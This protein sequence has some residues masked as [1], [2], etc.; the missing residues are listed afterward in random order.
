MK[1]VCAN[2]NNLKKGEKSLLSHQRVGWVG[3][4]GPGLSPDDT[5]RFVFHK[6]KG[7]CHLFSSY[8]LPSCK[9][10]FRAVFTESYKGCF[11]N[12]VP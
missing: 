10:L 2:E 5:E 3:N 11:S 8:T 7:F 4:T 12:C 9:N 6:N 1:G